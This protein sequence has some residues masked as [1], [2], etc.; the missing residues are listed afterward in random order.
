MKLYKFKI[1]D[2][3][4]DWEDIFGILFFVK[5]ILIKDNEYFLVRKHMITHFIPFYSKLYFKDNILTIRRSNLPKLFLTLEL[6]EIPIEIL[7]TAASNDIR[8]KAKEMFCR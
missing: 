7:L 4:G 2:L 3:R 8:T 6:K 1:V 5:Y